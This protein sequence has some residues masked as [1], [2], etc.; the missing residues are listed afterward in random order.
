MATSGSVNYSV[1][2]NDLFTG[3]METIGAIGEGDTISAYEISICA[4][5]LNML[6]KQWQGDH[7]FSRGLKVWSRKRGYL[8]LQTD[9]VSYSLGSTGDNWT[10]SYVTTTTTATSSSGG[11][12]ITVAS[13]TGLAANQYIGVELVTGA[14]QWTTIS[15]TPTTTVTLAA[16]LTANVASG[17]RVFAYTTKATA[18]LSIRTCLM[19]DTSGN[20]TPMRIIQTVEEYES[21]P[22]KTVDGMPFSVFFETSLPNATLYTNSA[23]TDVDRV[24]RITY[25]RPLEDFDATADEPDYPQEWFRTLEIGLARE[26]APVFKRPWTAEHKEIFQEAMALAKNRNPESIVSVYEPGRC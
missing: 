3:A 1:T 14:L 6:V 19:R 9:Q 23:P 25:T 7:D 10:N 12:T 26:I 5:K 15:G 24:L 8:F 22:S 2:R 18:P 11:S 20:D 21:I 4:R 16:S 17:A 13:A